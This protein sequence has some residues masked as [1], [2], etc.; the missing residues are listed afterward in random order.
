M[1]RLVLIAAALTVTAFA[2]RT[3]QPPG[4]ENQLPIDS[5]GPEPM[6]TVPSEPAGPAGPITSPTEDGGTR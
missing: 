1:R 6:Q 2:C 3:T 5:V 4:T